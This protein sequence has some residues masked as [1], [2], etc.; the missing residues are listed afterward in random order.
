[1]SN[2]ILQGKHAIVFGAAGSVGA[3]VAKEFAAEGA[4][5]FLAGR[6]KASLDAVAKGE[7]AL[8]HGW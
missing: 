7:N 6:T 2:P 1:M 4:E 5:V 3:A 8:I